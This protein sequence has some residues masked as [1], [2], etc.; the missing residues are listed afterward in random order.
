MNES[1]A[2]AAQYSAA[3]DNEVNNWN[4]SP[5]NTTAGWMTLDL[6]NKQQVVNQWNSAI[7]ADQRAGARARN[8]L[9]DYMRRYNR[10]GQRLD[11]SINGSWARNA[12]TFDRKMSD[13]LDTIQN[14]D[15]MSNNSTTLIA[16]GASD[17][18]TDLSYSRYSTARNSCRRLARY[19]YYWSSYSHRCLR[20]HVELAEDGLI[21]GCAGTQMGCCEDGLTQA[22]MENGC[23]QSNMDDNA[24]VA[25]PISLASSTTC[26][27]S[28]SACPAATTFVGGEFPEGYSCTESGSSSTSCI[29]I[30]LI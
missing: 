2:V 25:S 3:W 28:E 1:R 7:Q 20:H 15:D 26:V 18:V 12:N 11:R 19:G 29:P 16:T 5:S 23:E 21:G 10:A 6:D 30:P 8:D 22:T 9:Q 17:A 24:P 13:I 4:V 27:T 14:M